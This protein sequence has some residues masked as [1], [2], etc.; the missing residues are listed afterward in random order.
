M[1]RSSLLNELVVAENS[2]HHMVNYWLDHDKN[3]EAA[4]EYAQREYESRKDLFT[5][6]TFAWA[7]FKNGRLPEA[8]RVMKEALRTG[9]RDARLLY[10][11]GMIANA[12]GERRNAAKD[13]QL[14]LKLNPDFNLRQATIAKNTLESLFASI[15]NQ[16]SQGNRTSQLNKPKYPPLLTGTVPA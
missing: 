12:L 5:S 4:L 1:K 8:K 3:L 14:A 7:L 10:H 6:D 15:R 9:T 16:T 2:W 11:S 13:L